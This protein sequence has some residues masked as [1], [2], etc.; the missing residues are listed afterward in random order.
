M[1]AGAA[2]FD[3]KEAKRLERV[4][5]TP[6]VVAQRR[7]VVLALAP[8]PGEQVLDIG[9][10]PG[11]LAI[12]MGEAVGP[13]GRVE[14][15]DASAA[16]VALATE[17]AD[18]KPWIRF[19]QADAATL[20]FPDASL[21]AATATQVYLYV[22]DLA[23]ALAELHRVL[24]PGGRALILDTDWQS[25]VWHTTDGARMARILSAWEEHFANGFIARTLPAMLHAAGF[26]LERANAHVLLNVGY[27]EESYSA[28]MLPMIRR[29][30]PGR[31]GVTADEAEAW[32]EELRERGRDGSY[33]FSL[34]R[35]LFLAKKDG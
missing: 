14:G 20:P 33:F 4:Y 12:E 11:L 30:V 32:F 28:G 5:L 34:N 23:C 22:P 31:R 19:R 1:Q 8:Q 25:V 15:I 26:R 16:M 21:D 17:R 35:Y 24:K 3:E 10:G 18:G 7:E 29:F 9:S 13:S 6:D 27:E 2:L